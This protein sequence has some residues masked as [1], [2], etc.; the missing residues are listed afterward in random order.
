MRGRR[1]NPESLFSAVK[2]LLQRE[3]DLASAD[4]YLCLKDQFAEENPT[5]LRTTIG[6]YRSA[7]RQKEKRLA[8]HQ[9]R[10]HGLN[11]D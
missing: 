4:I 5:W 9:G 11:P 10:L 8:A 1:R 2:K 6:H 7:V 3:P